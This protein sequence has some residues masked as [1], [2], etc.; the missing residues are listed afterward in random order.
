MQREVGLDCKHCWL[1]DYEA[2]NTVKN[3]FPTEWITRLK[4]GIRQDIWGLDE[5][6]HNLWVIP[7]ACLVH[8]VAGPLPGTGHMLPPVTLW[9]SF[10]CVC[11]HG[12]SS[13]RDSPL[14]STALSSKSQYSGS[15]ISPSKSNA[16]MFIGS[17]YS[18]FH[19]SPYISADVIY[20]PS[21]TVAE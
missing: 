8:G 10:S 9:L 12:Q 20:S 21:V 16:P 4:K 18:Y 3:S 7:T 13:F 6:K 11:W 15:H 2:S 19:K 17:V 1:L 5:V 14:A